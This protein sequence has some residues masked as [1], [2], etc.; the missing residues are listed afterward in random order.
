MSMR[1]PLLFTGVLVCPLDLPDEALTLVAVRALVVA[2]SN[3]SSAT[4]WGVTMDVVG[5]GK[6]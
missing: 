1:G 6:A 5:G 2:M 4:A 3:P